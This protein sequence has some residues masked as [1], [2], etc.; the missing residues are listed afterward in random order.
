MQKM[1]LLVFAS[2]IECLNVFMNCI[3]EATSLY[4]VEIMKRLFYNYVRFSGLSVKQPIPTASIDLSTLR[5]EK[6]YIQSKF[7]GA[8]GFGLFMLFWHNV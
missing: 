1:S 6:C 8:L 5:W 3:F 7:G 4:F 2:F